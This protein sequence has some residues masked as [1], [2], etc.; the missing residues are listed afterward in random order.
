[1]HEERNFRHGGKSRIFF[2]AEEFIALPHDGRRQIFSGVTI[3][4]CLVTFGEEVRRAA[5]VIDNFGR[6]GLNNL[7]ERQAVPNE[8]RNGRGREELPFVLLEAFVEELLKQIAE[9]LQVG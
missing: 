7:V 1:M 3:I 5:R 6:F 9:C 4:D 8:L 2:D